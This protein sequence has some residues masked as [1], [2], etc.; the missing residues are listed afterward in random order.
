[1][2]NGHVKIPLKIKL[3]GLNLAVIE[4]VNINHTRLGL[5]SRSQINATK[6]SK[7]YGTQKTHPYSQLSY[8]TFPSKLIIINSW[9]LTKFKSMSKPPLPKAELQMNSQGKSLSRNPAGTANSLPLYRLFQWF[10]SSHFKSR[11]CPKFV[12]LPIAS[13]VV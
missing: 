1:M 12:R 8:L 6:G 9:I 5:D 7:N 3:I 13:V 2:K 4:V 10:Y 11:G